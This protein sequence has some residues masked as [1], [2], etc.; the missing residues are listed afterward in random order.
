MLRSYE[1][2]E[3]YLETILVLSHTGEPVRA[4]DVVNELS[5]TKAS[6]SVAMK[7]LREDGLVRVTDEGHILLTDDGLKIAESIYERHTLITDWLILLGVDKETA[8]YDACK[9]EHAM[10]DESFAAIRQH[11]I[12][13][14]QNVPKAQA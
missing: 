11:I 6:V 13:G 7:N 12:A 2:R 14:K 9:M 8:V 3:N 10:S 4:I 5:F 1:S